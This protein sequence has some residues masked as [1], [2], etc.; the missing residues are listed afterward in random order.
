LTEG[1]FTKAQL[2][3]L[4]DAIRDAIRV[5]VRE[6]LADAG[7]RI[8]GPDHQDDARRDFMFI[9]SMRKAVNGAAAKVG[10]SIIV[11]LIAAVFWLVNSG[12]DVWRG[13]GK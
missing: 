13:V 2:A 7:L 3:Q 5:A 1:P 9:R 10:W 11:A 12:L 6:E 4:T 8:D